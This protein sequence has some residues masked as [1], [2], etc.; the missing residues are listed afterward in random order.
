MMKVF[1]FDQG[2]MNVIQAALENRLTEDLQT[3]SVLADGEDKDC[4]LDSIQTTRETLTKI[5]DQ[6]LQELAERCMSY[7]WDRLSNEG[8][9]NPDVEWLA[10]SMGID[11]EDELLTLFI[12]AGFEEVSDDYD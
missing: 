3:A 12:Q 5:K 6:S 4:V 11:D 8:I 1:N 10:A 7:F 2:N 9:D